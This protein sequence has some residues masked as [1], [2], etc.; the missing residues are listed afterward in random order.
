MKVHHRLVTGAAL[1]AIAIAGSVPA[2]ATARK[3]AAATKH[4]AVRAR[5]QDSRD[6][7]IKALE[8]KID[9]LTQR[10]DQQETAQQATAQQA[11]TAQAAAVAAHRPRNLI[12][13]GSRSRRSRIFP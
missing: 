8:A 1:A 7:E 2:D 3:H 9:A 13:G 5:A 10:L 12:G 6:A 11:Q 4:G